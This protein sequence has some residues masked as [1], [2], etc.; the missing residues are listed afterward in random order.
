MGIPENF[1]I[2]GLWQEIYKMNS[3]HLTQ[4]EQEAEDY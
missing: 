1:L 4:S 2:K 3:E